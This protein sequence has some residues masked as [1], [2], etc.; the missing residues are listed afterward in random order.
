LRGEPQSRPY[1]DIITEFRQLI[2]HGYKEIVL[3]GVNIGKYNIA[4]KTSTLLFTDYLNS[5]ENS[6]ST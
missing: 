5:M 4:V 3:T 2:E 1:N 6:G